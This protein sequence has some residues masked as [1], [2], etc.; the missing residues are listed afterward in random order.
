MAKITVRYRDPLKELTRKD[1]DQ[2]DVT[3][4]KDVLRH[5]KSTYGAEAAKLAK[6][7][8]IAIDGDSILLRRGFATK[9]QE[10]ETVQFLPICGGG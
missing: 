10:G 9:L 8:L 3:A 2:L 4:I 7:M 1:E 6:S 5:V